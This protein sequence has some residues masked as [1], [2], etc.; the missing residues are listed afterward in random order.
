MESQLRQD[1]TARMACNDLQGAA[2]L[3]WA[4]VLNPSKVSIACAALVA[5]S[6]AHR[7]AMYK[8][9]SA[10]ESHSLGTCMQ[11]N[12]LGGTSL[13]KVFL[14]CAFPPTEG[15]S[16]EPPAPVE[17]KKEKKKKKTAKDAESLFAA[18][19]E[20]AEAEPAAPAPPAKG[21]LPCAMLGSCA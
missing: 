3:L 17:E 1:A 4:K 20:G 8:A 7:K 15:A 6:D 14:P 13:S 21:S 5:G 9:M 2:V 12:L 10:R 16:E 18:L 11:W 19:A